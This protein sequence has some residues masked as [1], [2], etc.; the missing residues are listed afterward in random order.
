LS[1]YVRLRLFECLLTIFV[2]GN[3]SKLSESEKEELGIAQNLPKS[4]ADAVTAAENDH[5]LE[6]LMPEG[7]LKHFLAMKK[8]EQE[9]LNKMEDD[10][11]QI[12]LLE[13]Y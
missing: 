10:E 8:D 2:I 1:K 3:P 5:D 13:R 6:A 11:R 4:L 9:M 7:M 12:W